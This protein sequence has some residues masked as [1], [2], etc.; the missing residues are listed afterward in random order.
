MSKAAMIGLSTLF[1]VGVLGA[2]AGATGKDEV[3]EDKIY[4]WQERRGQKQGQKERILGG[5]YNSFYGGKKKK[6]K[7]PKKHHKKKKGGKK[8]RHH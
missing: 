8:R 1:G 7:K 4:D 3:I 5:V 6:S 2:I